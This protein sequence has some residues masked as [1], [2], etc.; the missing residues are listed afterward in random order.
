LKLAGLDAVVIILLYLLGF[1]LGAG[2]AATVGESWLTLN[3]PILGVIVVGEG[4]WFIIRRWIG[5]R[6]SVETEASRQPAP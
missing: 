4:L 1:R 5:E 3:F 2:Y 6:V